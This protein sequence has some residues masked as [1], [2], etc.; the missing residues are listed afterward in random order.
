MPNLKRNIKNKLV[1][2]ELEILLTMEMGFFNSLKRKKIEFNPKP[3]S[4]H[5]SNSTEKLEAVENNLVNFH[6]ETTK[7]IDE[8]LPAVQKLCKFSAQIIRLFTPPGYKTRGFLA[9]SY[10]V[11][12]SLL[13]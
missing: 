1:E 3:F 11:L 10:P 8:I 2:P 9:A 5:K 7:K 6:L 4:N 13:L 12:Y